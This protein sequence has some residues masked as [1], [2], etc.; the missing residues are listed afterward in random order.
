MGNKRVYAKLAIFG[1][2][3]RRMAFVPKSGLLLKEN[4]PSDGILKIP[5]PTQGERWIVRALVLLGVLSMALF[6]IWF[7]DPNHVGNKP[8]YFLLT[9]ALGFRLLRLLH[10]WY[11]YLGISVPTPPVS[12]R[13][14]TVDMVT[15]F[16]PGE[17]YDMIVNTLKAMKAVTY[18]H[19]TYLCDEGNDPYIR[20]VCE[21][22]GVHHVYRGPVKTNAKAGNVNYCLE[23]HARGEITIILDPDHVPIPEFIDRVLPYF[24]DPRIGYVQ[25]VQAYSNRDESLIA[26]GAAE[27]TYHFYGPMMMSMNTYGTAQAIGANCAFRRAAIDSIGGHAPGLSEDMHTAMQLHARGWKSVY[28]PELLTRG[29]VPA[30]IS[31]YYKQQLKWSRGT[32]EL[33]FVVFP[34]LAKRF[35]WRQ[36]IHYLTIPMFF[37]YGLIGLIDLTVPIASLVMAR[38][39]WHVN[40]V[41]FAQVV[42]PMLVMS[43][44]IRQ[45]A[46]RWLLEEHER[47]FHMMGGILISG[48]WWIFLLG[49]IYSL[50]RIKVP[51]IPTPKNDEPTNEVAVSLP[52]LIVA[53]ICVA[54]AVYGLQIDWTPYSIGMAFFA[55]FNA[56]IMGTIGLLGMQRSLNTFTEKTNLRKVVGKWRSRWWYL[57]HQFLYSILRNSSLVVALVIILAIGGFSLL[58]YEMQRRSIEFQPPNQKNTGF[59]YAGL[60]TSPGQLGQLATFFPDKSIPSGLNV[61]AIPAAKNAESFLSLND[62]LLQVVQEQGKIPLIRWQPVDGLFQHMEIDSAGQRM[63]L[64]SWDEYLLACTEKVKKLKGPVFLQFAPQPDLANRGWGPAKP[65][66]PETYR[67]VWR[68]VRQ[69]FVLQ[70]VGNVAWVWTPGSPEHIFDYFPGNGYGLVDWIALTESHSDPLDYDWYEPWREE[71]ENSWLTAYKPVMLYNTYPRTQLPFLSQVQ[72]SVRQLQE[73]HPE[74]QSIVLSIELGIKS[75]VRSASAQM[76]PPAQPVAGQAAVHKQESG[77]LRPMFASNEAVRT[78]IAGEAGEFYLEVDGKPFFMKGVV[79]NLGSNWRDGDYPLTRERLERDFTLIKQMGGNAIRRYKPGIYDKNLL[80]VA[81]EMDIKVMYGF[82]FDTNV[83]YYTDSA[84][85]EAYI[86][87]V[88]ESVRKYKDYPSVLAWN[89]GSGTAYYLRDFFGQPYLSLVRTSY[90]KMLEEMARRIH[91]IDPTRPVFASLEDGNESAEAIL[92]IKNLAPSIDAIGFNT[93]FETQTSLLPDLMA[94]HYPN[95]PYFL[96]EFGPQGHQDIALARQS[97]GFLLETSTYE[98][99]RQYIRNWRDHVVSQEGKILGGFAYCWQDRLLG[100]A[101]WYG[102]TDYEGRLKPGYFALQK[103][104]TDQRPT[105]PMRNLEIKV[106]PSMLIPGKEYIFSAI[107]SNPSASEGYD[108]EWYLCKENYLKRVGGV[109]VMSGGKKVKVTV[110]E[111]PSNYRLYLHITD[112][113]GNVVTSSAPLKVEWPVKTK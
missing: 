87:E 35:T 32:F 108:Y 2:S 112:R 88:E 71:L 106:P 13:T 111:S 101:V 6:V 97:D 17:P 66:D 94:R 65:I 27:Q 10:E 77:E 1:R 29:L 40:L 74:V 41:E 84:K 95:K 31:A 33:L 50:L 49:F 25:C 81:D 15:T 105:M 9:F 53:A 60:S 56:L 38:V 8:L 21:E 113:N 37:L 110:P 73:V 64:S 62:S 104:W 107:T 42:T 79:Y 16:C 76:I 22:L 83:D 72:T 99:S 48:T 61:I 80:R 100:S 89:L 4:Q 86:R 44:L 57:R 55:L 92:A 28:L 93:F 30:T 12:T 103:E 24:E 7:A 51:Y 54:A 82:W 47:G 20:Q 59:F 39:P 43:M 91:A 75:P 26:R 45:Y 34:R 69:Y 52:N 90:V 102:L 109:N 58:R 36:L 46:Q 18:P 5:A 67:T 96:S 14:W 23:N 85:V 68:Y 70:G 98:R 19:E 78:R 11:H 3:I 63:P